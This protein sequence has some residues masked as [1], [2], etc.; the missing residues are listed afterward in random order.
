[1]RRSG[2]HWIQL[3]ETG[4]PGSADAYGPAVIA[5]AVEPAIRKLRWDNVIIRAIP[6]VVPKAGWDLRG[7]R[8]G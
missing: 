1:M 4:L 5:A 7:Q 2:D 3:I 8:I 6:H